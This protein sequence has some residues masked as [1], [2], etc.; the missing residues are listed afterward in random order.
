MYY[1]KGS[2]DGRR[3]TTYVAGGTAAYKVFDWMSVTAL[4]NYTSKETNGD[5][6]PNLK[7]LSAVL[8]LVLITPSNYYL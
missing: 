2:N 3:D 4:A 5:L 6:S 1:D 8:P 7:I